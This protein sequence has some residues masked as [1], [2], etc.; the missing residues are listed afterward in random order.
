MSAF[1]VEQKLAAVE[2]WIEMLRPFRSQPGTSEHQT[3]ELLKAIAVDLRTQL[4][5]AG[6]TAMVSL[7]HRIDLARRQKARLGYYEIGTLQG[8]GEEVIG[9]WPVLQ[10]A[11]AAMGKAQ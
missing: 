1:T 10:R 6:P 7:E 11:L 8:I 3:R 9:R 4:A 5:G 2:H